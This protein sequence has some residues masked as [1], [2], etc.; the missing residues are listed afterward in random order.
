MLSSKFDFSTI[1]RNKYFVLGA[2]LIILITLYLKTTIFHYIYVDYVY[3]LG[4]WIKNI[5]E[6][7]FLFSLKEP[8]YNYTLF[9]MYILTLIAKLNFDWLISIKVVSIFFEYVLAFYIGKI[10]YLYLKKYVVIW[11]S[12]LIIPLIPTVFIN[13][14]YMSQCDSIYASFTIISIYYLLRDKY[15]FSFLLLGVAFAIKAQTC[16]VFPFYLVYIVKNK[17]KFYYLLIIPI[18]YILIALPALAI[19]KPFMDTMLIYL[20]Q[21]QFNTNL[22]QYFSNLYVWMDVSDASW[23]STIKLIGT[24]FVVI[25]TLITT[26]L[27]SNRKYKFDFV[28]WMKFLF[29]SVVTVPFFLPGMLERYMYLAD[30]LAIVYIFLNVRKFYLGLGIIYIS[31]YCYMKVIFSCSILPITFIPRVV[32]LSA[33]YIPIEIVA[34]IYFII[35][36]ILVYDFIKDLKEHSY[37]AM[38]EI[39]N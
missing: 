28:L 2:L 9:Y 24:S 7:N 18:V 3:F 39:S 21:S 6:N 23:I 12:I 36:F 8:F 37:R 17:L 34:V 19:G 16:M 29:I 10:L 11:I 38:P 22:V 33:F 31:F 25:V 27:L 15:V 20:N 1:H 30:V 32:I 13:S 26:Y 35:I 5:Q 4:P 14:S